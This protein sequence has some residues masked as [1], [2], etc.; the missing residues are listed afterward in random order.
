MLRLP[1]TWDAYLAT[2]S[3]KHRHELR[4]KMRKLERELPDVRVRQRHRR[5]PGWDDALGQFLRCI[6][7]RATGKAQLHGRAHGALLPRARSRPSPPRAGARS[8]SSTRRGR[9]WPSS[10]ALEWDGTVGLYNS[11]FDPDH[12]PLSP[13]IVLLAPRDPRRHRAAR[14]R[15]RLP[16]GRGALQVRVRPGA[17]RD[18]PQRRGWRREPARRDASVHT[19]PLAAL[20][21]KETGGMNVYVRES[22]R[23]LGRMGVHGGRLHALAE[24][25][26][27]AASCRSATSAR[28]IHL[29]A[30]PSGRC[31][32][33]WCTST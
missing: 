13:G 18:L 11:G 30:G 8:G 20:G 16:A 31:R 5:G 28:V 32:A 10:S 2:L 9:R 4:R 7:S 19:C 22:A 6:G 12:A 27:S 1:E 33:R 25:G 29:P 17:R 15:L 24:S 21:G 23:E 3:G 14:P 26:A